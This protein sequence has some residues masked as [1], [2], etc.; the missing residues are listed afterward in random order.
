MFL[1]LYVTSGR[2]LENDL[3]RTL[4]LSSGENENVLLPNLVVEDDNRRSLHMFER[5]FHR[6]TTVFKQSDNRTLVE[7][8]FDQRTPVH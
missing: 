2:A 8:M 7:I 3:G 6:P 1:L 5:A 4:L